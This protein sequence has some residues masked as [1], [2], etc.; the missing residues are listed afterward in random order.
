MKMSTGGTNEIYKS[1][2]HP[3][4]ANL[5]LTGIIVLA[6]IAGFHWPD[7]ADDSLYPVPKVKIYVPSK[8]GGTTDATARAFA[9]SLERHTGVKTVVINQTAGGGT[10]AVASVASAPADGG[11][12][13]VFHA[14]LH[15]A[16]GTGRQEQSADDLTPLATISR[17]TDVY[18]VRTGAPFDSLDGLLNHSVN[19]DLTIA[20]QLG[21]TT[22]L[23][24]SAL[25]NAAAQRG[26][27]LRPVAMGSMAQRLTSLLGE[28]VDVS[29]VDLK[30]A[31]Q[32][33]DAGTIKPL[34]VISD[35]RDPFEP[36]WPTAIEQGVDI[37]L[38]QVNELYA[39]GNMSIATRTHLDGLLAAALQDPELE[40]DLARVK[41]ALEYRDSESAKKFIQAEALQVSRILDQGL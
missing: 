19:H 22:Q 27:S 35:Q 41:Q 8:P 28:Q 29:I 10:V 33:L 23:K 25:A 24:A 6:L 7:S 9:R 37:N 4:K 34:A 16:H 2:K 38:A 39:P 17:A 13:L 14:M 31:R 20:S 21:G 36:G 30:T 12:L 3:L 26:G 11:S 1:G 15:V 18:V 5:V 32:Y 40:L